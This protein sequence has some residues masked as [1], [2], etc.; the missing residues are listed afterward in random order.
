[1]THDTD[2]ADAVAIVAYLTRIICRAESEEERDELAELASQLT[3]QLC[4]GLD[5]CAEA[6]ALEGTDQASAMERLQ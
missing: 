1:M 2:H 4:D 3:I 6:V 5:L